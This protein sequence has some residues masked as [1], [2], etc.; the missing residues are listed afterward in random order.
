M[1]IP[2]QIRLR[3]MARCDALEARIR[4]NAE[5]LEQFHSRITSCRVTVEESH[6]HQRKGRQFDVRVEA[7]APARE[8][9]VSTLHHDEDVYVALRDAFDSV[10]RQLEDVVRKS[11]DD[12][13]L[14]RARRSA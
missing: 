3:H 4:D 12:V 8:E 2:L 1:Q 6:R 13:G 11:R 14:H 10:R 9:C 7:R 5:K